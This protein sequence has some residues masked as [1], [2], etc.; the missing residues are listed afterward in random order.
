M[1][2]ATLGRLVVH[3][4]HDLG[5]G[6]IYLELCPAYIQTMDAV[7]CTYE[8]TRRWWSKIKRLIGWQEITA[9]HAED[10]G[11]DL[12]ELRPGTRHGRHMLIREE[13]RDGLRALCDQLGCLP[14]IPRDWYSVSPRKRGSTWMCCCPH[15]DD[16]NP[17]MQLDPARRRATCHGCG[18]RCLYDPKT[19]EVTGP[20][21]PSGH[22]IIPKMCT[23][24]IR[25]VSTVAT[26][27]VVVTGRL[28]SRGLVR[29]ERDGSLFDVMRS[30]R[31]RRVDVGT[32]CL[33]DHPRDLVPDRLAFI[34]EQRIVR[35]TWASVTR[36]DGSPG[37]RVT[38]VESEATRVGHLLVDVDDLDSLGLEPAFRL[39]S[40]GA[41]I[42]QRLSTLGFRGCALT[43]TSEHGVQ[44][45]VRL[46]EPKAP[47]WRASP[48]AARCH[49]QIESV[50]MD[51]LDRAGFTGGHVDQNARG[52]NRTCRLP[53]V[54]VRRKGGHT[55]TWYAELAYITPKEDS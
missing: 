45:V 53:G 12:R 23:T 19:R 6:L 34:D 40:V 3:R 17:S 22:A 29:T 46:C 42:D 47:N 43:V 48:D 39:E 10:L 25:D 36:R 1:I 33:S 38:N 50:V 41:R 31:C 5:G 20:R 52:A 54:R 24:E 55:T 32:V 49:E 16:S 26:P 44:V 9:S 30:T 28:H 18:A 8:T 7:T 27:G 13:T 11:V 21:K 15:H 14:E 2:T 4:H 35:R 37:W 51:E